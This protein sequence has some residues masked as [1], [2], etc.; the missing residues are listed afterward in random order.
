MWR[1]AASLDFSVK[2][3]DGKTKLYTVRNSSPSTVDQTYN[4]AVALAVLEIINDPE[5]LTYINE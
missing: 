2:F 4:G 5:V 1:I 3:G